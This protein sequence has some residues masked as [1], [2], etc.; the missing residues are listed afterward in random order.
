MEL[1]A[2]VSVSEHDALSR[3]VEPCL[4]ADPVNASHGAA[5]GQYLTNVYMPRM[6]DEAYGCHWGSDRSSS[7]GPISLG[8][9]PVARPLFRPGMRRSATGSTLHEKANHCFKTNWLSGLGFAAGERIARD[10]G[11]NFE[12]MTTYIMGGGG[13][14]S[15]HA[16]MLHQLANR[17]L[18]EVSCL[19]ASAA[20]AAPLHVV[21]S[22]GA[23]GAARDSAT[24][25]SVLGLDIT[26]AAGDADADAC[27]LKEAFEAIMPL[28]SYRKGAHNSAISGATTW[29][30][31]GDEASLRYLRQALCL[32]RL[33]LLWGAAAEVELSRRPGDF[34]NTLRSTR[35]GISATMLVGALKKLCGVVGAPTAAVLSPKRLQ[36]KVILEDCHP[37]SGVLAVLLNALIV[38]VT[39]G[40]ARLPWIHEPACSSA[41]CAWS[42][43]L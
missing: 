19:P 20:P 33:R 37:P 14:D 24:T 28:V 38:S 6:A 10:I 12:L 13:A 7:G 15:S 40:L 4:H 23:A 29:A 32:S 42:L 26:D 22:G 1:P 25:N 8:S 17:F 41:S 2:T 34:M 27:H 36:S 31:G 21:A 16:G 39:S 18:N 30:S 3:T 35:G 11:I 43:G 5:M 9:E